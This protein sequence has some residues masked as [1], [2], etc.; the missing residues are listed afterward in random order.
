[1]SIPN[2]N[3][4]SFAHVYSCLIAFASFFGAFVASTVYVI[5]EYMLKSKRGFG[6]QKFLPS[7]G[8]SD[9][10]S[11]RMAAFGFFMLT[12]G[13]IA[14]AVG[15]QLTSGSFWHWNLKHS[16]LLIT[17]LVYAA[18]LHVRGISG[19]RGKLTNRLLTAGFVCVVITLS[20]SNFMTNNWH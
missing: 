9:R 2:G 20:V 1:M 4:W 5:H 11:Y 3:H 19:W 15:S 13:L 10:I 8:I 6:I 14:F 18:Y 16:W 17:W 12:V 7:L